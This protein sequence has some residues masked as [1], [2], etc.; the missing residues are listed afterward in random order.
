MESVLDGEHIRAATVL[1]AQCSGENNAGSLCFPSM[2]FEEIVRHSPRRRALPWIA[3]DLFYSGSQIRWTLDWISGAF[4]L[5][6]RR[7][8]VLAEVGQAL[9][10]GSTQVL[11]AYGNDT[12]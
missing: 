5:R 12:W 8:E 4:N 9:R 2:V 6:L 11:L 7:A 10:A 1:H 3:E